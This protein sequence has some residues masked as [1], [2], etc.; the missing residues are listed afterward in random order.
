MKSRRPPQRHCVPQPPAT[1]S[2]GRCFLWIYWVEGVLEVLELYLSQGI[3]G[4]I[5]GVWFL[6]LQND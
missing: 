3:Q 6:I 2:T 5:L 1:R 4:V